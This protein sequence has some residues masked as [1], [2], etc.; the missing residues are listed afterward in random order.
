MQNPAGWDTS[1]V[2]LKASAQTFWPEIDLGR[3][4]EEDPGLWR[5][6]AY[7]SDMVECKGSAHTPRSVWL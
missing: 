6:G 7:P 4:S 3:G 2:V 1:P 5:E